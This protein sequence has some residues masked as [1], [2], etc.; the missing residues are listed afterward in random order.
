MD[1]A[2]IDK[3]LWGN[4][5]EE[6]VLAIIVAILA[7]MVFE[8][9]KR[10]LIRKANIYTVGHLKVL[11]QIIEKVLRST[12]MFFL[13]ILAVCL[14]VQVLELSGQVEVLIG[15]I[16]VMAL[17]IQAVIWG[18]SLIDLYVSRYA[19]KQLLDDADK[20]T[21]V[22]A[23]GGLAKI[24]LG[25]VLFLVALDNMGVNVTTLIAGLGVGGIAVALAAQSILGD[26]FASL[27]IVLD[28]P[29]VLGDFIIVGT[30]MGN[31]EHIGLKTT[32]VRSL[33]GEQLIFPNSDLLQ[34]RI[35]NYKRMFER[36]IVFRFGVIYQT[37][38]AQLKKIPNM[39]REVITE[40][41]NSRI[42][43]VHF[44]N[45]G[46]SS[47]DFETVY[48]V[49]QSDYNIYMDTQQAINLELFRRFEEEGIE[50][51]YPTRTLYMTNVPAPKPSIKATDVTPETSIKASSHSMP[52][53][54]DG[55]DEARA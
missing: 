45:Y 38:Y 1:L 3:D 7:F 29:F 22:R 32:R 12:K 21:T 17:I 20:A 30:D 11:G 9:V 43:R 41:P 34:S 51:A 35:R 50:F 5:V 16:S 54:G 40:V 8:F 13:F 4:P 23:A 28:K 39:V 15:K 37:T 55:G 19:G 36:R 49:T 6:W 47:L 10:L 18:N 48:W 31:I 25:T 14:G 2:F 52:T 24:I 42:D 46:D 26:L 44:F 27:S 53:E 33:S